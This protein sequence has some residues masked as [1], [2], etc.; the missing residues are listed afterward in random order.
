MTGIEFVGVPFRVAATLSGH[1][2]FSPFS[3]ESFRQR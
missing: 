3:A 1:G 2:L